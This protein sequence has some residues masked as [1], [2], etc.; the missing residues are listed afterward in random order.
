[1]KTTTQ[2][3][4]QRIL[5]V[6]LLVAALTSAALFGACSAGSQAAGHGGGE[7]ITVSLSINCRL[8]VEAGNAVALA[9]AD[10][11]GGI[12]ESTLTLESGATVYAALEAS[13][14]RTDTRNSSMGIYLIGIGGLSEGAIGSQSGWIYYVNGVAGNVSSNLWELQD[15]DAIEWVYVVEPI[16][17]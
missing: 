10:S 12:Y 11:N 15:G 9:I 2:P 3:K 8:A 14:V 1:M 16:Q 5:L 13:G 4:A 7:P 17:P 6:C